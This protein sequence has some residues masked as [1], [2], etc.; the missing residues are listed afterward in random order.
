MSE[1]SREA[2]ALIRDGH[3]V[4][5]PTGGDRARVAAAL[6]GRLAPGALLVAKEASAA[7]AKA[8]A[9]SKIGAAVAGVGLVV[10]GATTWLTQSSDPAASAPSQAPRTTVVPPV[11]V[12]ASPPAIVAPSPEPEAIAPEAAPAPVRK[13]SASDRF[14]EEVAM[15]SKAATALRAG[16]AAESLALLDAHRRKFPGSRLVEEERAARAQALCALGN[17]SEAA[18]E[19]SRLERVA[20]QSPHLARIKRA[21]GL[22]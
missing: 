14:A 9:W 19:I 22:P 16:R 2:Q 10:A 21:C 7:G 17:R 6:A 4:L 15:L 5:R 18:A 3:A 20:P 8:V 13:Q 12:P 11:A 1:L